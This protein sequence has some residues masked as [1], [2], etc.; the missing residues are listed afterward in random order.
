[1]DSKSGIRASVLRD[2]VADKSDSCEG[3]LA[4]QRPLAAAGRSAVIGRKRTFCFPVL[5][6]EKKTLSYV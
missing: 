4:T 1:M 3:R 5:R 2:A 6:S